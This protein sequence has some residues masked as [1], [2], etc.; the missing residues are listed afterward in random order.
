MVAFCHPVGIA[1]GDDIDLA[2]TIEAK[3]Q[4]H[5]PVEK[6]AVMADDQHGAVIIGND[7]LQ[8]V[9][10]F[11]IEVIGWLVEYQQISFTCKFAR[12]QYPRTLPTREGRD[13]C[14]DQCGVEQK[15][16]EIALNMLFHTA[17]HDPVAAI[18]DHI[19]DPFI[20]FEQLALLVDDDAGQRL[21][22]RDPAA[23]WLALA[24]EH[25]DQR[26]LASAVRAN[27]T[28]PVAALDSE[29]EVFDDCACSPISVRVEPSR[30]THRLCVTSRHLDWA[31]CERGGGERLTNILGVDDGLGLTVV[32]RGGE[33]CCPLRPHHRC[34]RGAHFPQFRQPSLIAFTPRGHAAFKPVCLDLQLGVHAVGVARIL[35]VNP[36]SPR[37]ITAEADFASAQLTAVEPE[38]LLGQPS[39]KRAVMADDHERA[40]VAH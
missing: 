29:G 26:G 31:R 23:I 13:L 36:L 21:R 4:S 3:R 17:N 37:V 30:D 34:T 1:T 35:G 33:L 12:K 8:E 39:Q 5:R 25:P 24:G 11:Q 16:F 20:A 22:E 40:L 7:L 28:D 14:V 38:G 10:R 15:V 6:V 27:N 2:R 19:A 18:G 32:V 9:E